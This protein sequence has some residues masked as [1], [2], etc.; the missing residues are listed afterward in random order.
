MNTFLTVI[1]MAAYMAVVVGIG[2]YFGKKN[3]TSDDYFI[4]GRKLGPW[5]T[6]MSAEAS[7]MSSWLLMGLP[8]VAYFTGFGDAGWTA[9]G[10]AIG[11]YLNWKVVAAR[12]RKY[13]EVSK[14]SITLP[15]FFSNR[16]RDEKKILMTI[17]SIM[18]II[19]FAVYTATGFAACG[20]L[21]HSVLGFPYL[22]TM[23]ICGFVI[24]LY[25]SIGGFLAAST[26]DLV[27]GLLMSFSIVLVL[28][29]GLVNAGGIG[30]VVEHAKSLPGYLDLLNTYN[31]ETGQSSSYGIIRMVSGL[32]WGLGYFGV[33]HILIRFM[34]IKNSSEIKKSRRIAMIWVVI[35]LLVAVCIGFTGS[36]LTSLGILPALN[37]SADAERI[38]IIMTN[39][40][41]PAL[42]AGVVLS[43]ILAATMSTA[44]SQL[45]MASSCV[46]QNLYKKFFNKQATDK[47]VLILSRVTTLLV[48]V[49]AMVIASDQNSSI[50]TLVSYAWSGFG[51]AFGPLVIFSLFWKRTTLKGAI[52]GM[53]GGGCLSLA[54]S[55]WIKK[56]GG[57]FSIYE[58]LPAFLFSSLL[59]VVV[60]LLD[61]EP[62][63]EIQKE[64]HSVSASHY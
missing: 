10:L 23:I 51:A 50:F 62:S 41:L 18:I 44:D 11:T 19:F 12:L 39:E 59:I 29:I 46:G 28:I 7:D 47:Q 34:A 14:N 9:I 16:F 58:L 60:S 36:A 55:L 54:W 5:V 8:G 40:F 45:L 21:F 31:P 33:P 2:I 17:S 26:T 13:S 6:A 38:F 27:Q 22:P 52:A 63:Q 35:S 56:L 24:V 15:D 32:A 49:F 61:Q 57:I 37:T 20:K 48:A 25:T 42:L 53:L 64:F 3:K 30:P 1:S 4:G 43:G